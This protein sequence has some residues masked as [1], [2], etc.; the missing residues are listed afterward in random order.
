VDP[1]LAR[2]ALVE[3]LNRLAC[4]AEQERFAASASRVRDALERLRWIDTTD[5]PKLL[6]RG[7]V[8]RREHDLL[9]HFFRFARARLSPIPRDADA[10]AFTRS[11]PGWQ[12]VR[13]RAAELV[14][15]LDAFVDLG[16]A[17]WGHQFQGRQRR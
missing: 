1:A 7:D 2:S 3:D 8:S 6:A 9:E 10:L 13:E 16:V 5:L 17:G 14:A 4:A 15:A 12:A 11:D